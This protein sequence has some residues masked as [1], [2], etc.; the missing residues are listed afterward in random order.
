[1]AQSIRDKIRSATVGKQAKFR[2]KIFNY[3]GVDVEFR[4]PSIK[5]KKILIERSKGKDGEFDMVNFL[6]WAVIANTYVPETNELVFDDTDYD[7]L[8]EQP[9]GSFVDKFGAEI[10]ELMNEEDSKNS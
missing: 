3:E 1:M 7:V 5:A 10:A 6:V 4:Q 8:V 2:S 9:T